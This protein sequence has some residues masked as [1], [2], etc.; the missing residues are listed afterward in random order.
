MTTSS[1]QLVPLHFSFLFPNIW[2]FCDSLHKK[3][4]KKV[5]SG[6]CHLRIAPTQPACTC[7]KSAMVHQNNIW[8]LFKVNNKDS[9]TTS[10]FAVV[11]LWWTLSRFQILLWCFIVVQVNSCWLG[12]TATNNE[13]HYCFSQRVFVKWIF[14]NIFHIY[15]HIHPCTCCFSLSLFFF[16][17][18]CKT[19]SVW[20][21]YFSSTYTSHIDYFSDHFDTSPYNYL[22]PFVFHPLS[23]FFRNSNC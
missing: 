1:L 16:L 9:T 7:S 19:L 2:K 6:C 20:T 4:H 8:N 23:Q 22:V 3:V 10:N 21:N 12:S 13:E 14:V 11:S 17:S 5:K 15:P 18:I